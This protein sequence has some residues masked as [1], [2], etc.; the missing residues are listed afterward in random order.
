MAQD[1][2]IILLKTKGKI[3][4]YIILKIEIALTID[5]LVIEINLNKTC[6]KNKT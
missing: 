4:P 5:K 3:Q 2:H 6:G 1:I